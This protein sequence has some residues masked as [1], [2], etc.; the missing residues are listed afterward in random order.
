MTS[1]G[2]GYNALLDVR[3]ELVDKLVTCRA[4]PNVLIV[5]AK[6]RGMIGSIQASAAVAPGSESGREKAEQLV[7]QILEATKTDDTKVEEFAQLLEEN[8]LGE[9]AAFLRGKPT[10]H[11]LYRTATCHFES[12]SNVYQVMVTETARRSSS[13]SA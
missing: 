4:D 9:V 2:P 7:N 8:S 3:T 6:D 5:K 12:R 1:A 11:P 13:L 10:E